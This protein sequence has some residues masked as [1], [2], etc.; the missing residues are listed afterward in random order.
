[1]K[2]RI[3][4]LSAVALLTCMLTPRA[5]AGPFWWTPDHPMIALSQFSSCDGDN[6]Q[7][8]FLPDG[9][10]IWVHEEGGLP[11]DRVEIVLTSGPNVRWWKGIEVWDAAR[12]T[13]I[14]SLSTQDDDHGPKSMVFRVDQLR[15]AYLVFLKAKF[16]GIHTAMYELQERLGTQGGK[17]LSFLWDRD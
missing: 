9:D 15:D 2:Q 6:C 1:M 4:A 5:F 10:E 13:I 14:G 17:R 8:S 16:L 7:T 12:D 11:G 3:L